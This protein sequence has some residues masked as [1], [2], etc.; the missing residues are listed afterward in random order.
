MFVQARLDYN[1]FSDVELASLVAARDAE[2]VRLV[3]E[4]NNRRLFRTAWSI[5]KN[6]EDA[7]DV[8]QSAYL[9][10]FRAIADFA[11]GSS[12]T[13]W[14]TRI[15]INE[16]LCRLRASKRKRAHLEGNSVIFVEDY[17]EKL[18]RGSTRHSSPEAF[19]AGAQIRQMLEEAI[20]SLP[21]TF[22]MVFILRDI[23]GLSVAEVAETLDISPPTV[24][25]RHHRA[26]RRLQIELGPELRNAL[27]GTFPFAGADC[28]ELTDR[29]LRVF[30]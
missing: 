23:E 13:T 10:G 7:E 28:K 17:R 26:R 15:V 24:K 16:S 19:V 14:L 12:L 29:V 2:A 22:R 27:I 30:V 21:P 20:A 8:V 3:T 18:M 25:S 1:A 9:R 11:G 6:R 5:L 4:R